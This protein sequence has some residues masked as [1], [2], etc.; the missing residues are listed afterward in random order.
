VANNFFT[1]MASKRILIVDDSRIILHA[2]SMKLRASGYEVM[3]AEDGAGGVSIARQHRPDLILLDISFPPD[4]GHGG[5]VSWDGFLIMDW[6]KRME[7]AKTIPV[8]I[9]TGADPAIYKDRALAS[10]AVSFFHKPVN[11][12][13]LLKAVRQALGEEPPTA[14]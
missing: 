6:L 12:E 5:G 1:D 8:I 9:V 3:T 10:G 4:V 14:G 7:E 11:P 13:D 2:L